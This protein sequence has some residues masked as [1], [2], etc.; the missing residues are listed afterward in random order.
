MNNTPVV[1][2]KN[3]SLMVDKNDFLRKKGQVVKVRRNNR[4]E[5][6]HCFLEMYGEELVNKEILLFCW[7]DE[8]S[9]Y[10]MEYVGVIS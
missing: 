6:M 9:K 7:D 1:A 4:Q 5:A 10:G 8:F 2:G 3:Y